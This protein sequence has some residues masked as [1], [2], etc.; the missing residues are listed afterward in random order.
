MPKHRL[1]KMVS[2]QKHDGDLGEEESLCGW[3]GSRK[4][5]ERRLAVSEHD[6]SKKDSMRKGILAQNVTAEMR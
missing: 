1:T 6:I 4:N 5:E 2:L 3:I